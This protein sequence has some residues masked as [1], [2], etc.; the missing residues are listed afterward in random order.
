MLSRS[1]VLAIGVLFHLIY[2]RS[3]FDIYFK[4]PVVSVSEQFTSRAQNGA[5]GAEQTVAPA[6]RLFLIVGD[7]LRADKLFE[8]PG[9]APFLHDKALNSG[10]WG[11]SHTRVPT[12][13]RPGHVAMIA[14]LYE[15]VSAV[16]TGWQLNPIHFDSVFNQSD[17]T[18]SWGSPDILPMFREGATNKDRINCS[19]Y[20]PEAEDFTKES[21]KLDNWVFEQVHELFLKAT[22]NETLS[23]ELK[24]P[25]TIY[26]LHLL[27]LDMA[28][29]FHRPYSSE[30]L[31][32]IANVDSGIANLMRTLEA[33]W[34][35]DELAKTA[36]LF[37][38]DHGM[39]D[40]GSHGDGDPVN[41]RTPYITWGAGL[42]RP[43]SPLSDRTSESLALHHTH[44][45][46]FNW[47]VEA[48]ERVDV[49]QADL[50]VLMSYLIGVN[51]PKNGAGSLPVEVLE[52]PDSQLSV[53][54][55]QNA[56]QIH[57]Q[58]TS[59]EK[60]RAEKL[61]FSELITFSF[62]KDFLE[63]GKALIQNAA[64]DDLQ[65][66]SQE[67][68][69]ESLKGMR[70]LQRYDWL[71]LR[72]V[73]T[74]G[75]IGWMVFVLIFVINSYVLPYSIESQKKNT[76]TKIQALMGPQIVPG[77]TAN[78]QGIPTIA[79]PITINDNRNQTAKTAFVGLT[80]T[81]VAYLAERTSPVSYYAYAAFP[82]FFWFRIA[83]DLPP[84]LKALRDVKSSSTRSYLR[85]GTVTGVLGIMVVQ[86]IVVAYGERRIISFL[87]FLASVTPL[88]Y[89]TVLKDTKMLSTAWAALC[90][91]M[92]TFTLLPTV[93]V[94]DIRFVT[95][96][97]A[98]MVVVGVTYIAYNGGTITMGAQVGLIAL[99]TIATKETSQSLAN[100]HG[101][102]F[103]CQVIGWVALALSLVLPLFHRFERAAGEILAYQHRLMILFLT[104][105][106]TFVILSISYEGLFYLTF[107]A[108]LV[109]WIHLESAI[110]SSLAHEIK[111]I[112]PGIPASASEQ[113]G[114]RGLQFSDARIAV[115]FF[116]L[117]QAAFFGTGNI[118]SVSSFSLDSVYRLIPVFNPFAMGLLLL[119][120]LLVPFA[121]ISAN[122]GILNRK[123]RVAPSALFMTVLTFC[124]LLTLNFFWMVKDEGSWLEIGSSISA[125]VIGG[126]LILFVISLEKVSDV[127]VGDVGIRGLE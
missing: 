46:N 83:T 41:T 16:T 98:I 92:S 35:P 87:W 96:G 119:F 49:A 32:N 107:W 31:N 121:V 115:Y 7:G 62:S 118:A 68:I 45:E 69:G 95:L 26:F 104:F 127:M 123:L 39:S 28:G 30:Y 80:V 14:G 99:A 11:I 21:S 9:L 57:A 52:G 73:I 117:I 93:Q 61:H 55:F 85:D 108:L 23:A 106:P 47:S 22:M 38:A 86:G 10:R 105:G 125:F 100:K 67:W 5:A 90:F 110:S 116:F 4:S 8:N 124:D 54:L 59:K 33:L 102:P 72:T 3:I 84:M 44:L 50:A 25:R 42:K 40:W 20:D 78:L 36:F 60:F 70:Y 103:G 56:Q 77:S 114:F 120:K 24:A 19:M 81:T 51:F 37:T 76:D 75:Y 94:E 79:E 2:L 15:D 18:Y 71:F 101:L 112:T 89:S 63:T 53:A 88:F 113:A 109:V 43:S 111:I 74:L 29:H 122:L 97:G 82:L 48:V 12:E 64:W 34:G 66:T 17:K 65:R 91:A 6:E 27:G 126:M 58:Y 1:A 13:S